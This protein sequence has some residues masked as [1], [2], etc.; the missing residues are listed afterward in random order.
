M[1]SPDQRLA[2]TESVASAIPEVSPLGNKNYPV[3]RVTKNQPFD[4]IPEC[5]RY[6]AAGAVSIGL[7]NRI[8]NESVIRETFPGDTRRLAELERIGFPNEEGL[9]IHVVEASTDKE[10]L[11]FDMFPEYLH[12]H[13]MP[14]APYTIAVSYDV[15]AN[16]DMFDWATGVINDR[17]AP[18]LRTAGAYELAE[19][20]DEDAV[21]AAVAQLREYATEL[22]KSS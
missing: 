19:V 11:R 2:S 3:G 16:G 21:R 13:Y 10:F 14:A 1:T 4:P 22:S 17:L 20:V 8:L 6:F 9:S 15:A 12:Y 5:T 7:E 18:M